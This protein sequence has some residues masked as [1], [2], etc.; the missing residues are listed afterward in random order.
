MFLEE[1]TCFSCVTFLSGGPVVSPRMFID[2]S[3]ISLKFLQI[4]DGN[5]PCDTRSYRISAAA[6]T[7]QDNKGVLVHLV[8]THTHTHARCACSG[9]DLLPVRV[10]AVP[11]RPAHK[12]MDPISGHAFNETQT[13]TRF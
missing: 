8:H 9:D 12:E 7:V 5:L 6:F 13:E 1:K 4:W 10:H 2:F 3:K 11:V